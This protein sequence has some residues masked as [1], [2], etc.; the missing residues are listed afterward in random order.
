VIVVRSL[1]VRSIVGRWHWRAIGPFFISG[2]PPGETTLAGGSDGINLS[3]GLFLGRVPVPRLCFSTGVHW[4]PQESQN[5]KYVEARQ[6]VFSCSTACKL[7]I[8]SSISVSRHSA[9]LEPLTIPPEIR[10]LVG[11]APALMSLKMVGAL[12]PVLADMAV[13]LISFS[14]RSFAISWFVIGVTSPILNCDCVCLYFGQRLSLTL[15]VGCSGGY[16]K[17]S[18]KEISAYLKRE[19]PMAPGLPTYRYYV[20]DW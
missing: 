10:T 14:V 16:H 8:H 4:S 5:G 12:I 15:Y 19:K 3:D 20:P 2:S 13:M 17:Q 11:K 9:S 18:E 1:R 7:R 6:A